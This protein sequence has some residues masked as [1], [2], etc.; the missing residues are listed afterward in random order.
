MLAPAR[1]KGNVIIEGLPPQLRAPGL[2]SVLRGRTLASLIRCCCRD[3]SLQTRLA[4]RIGQGPDFSREGRAPS[5][6]LGEYC[7]VP[8]SRAGQRTLTSRYGTCGFWSAHPI[9]EFLADLASGSRFAIDCR[10]DEWSVLH[11]LALLAHPLAVDNWFLLAG[12]PF[13]L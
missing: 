12:K 2:D 1:G 6:Q 3:Y 4:P 8:P 9:A 10:F 11:V 7:V 5:G 13:W